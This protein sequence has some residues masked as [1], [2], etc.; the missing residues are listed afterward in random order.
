MRRYQ[1]VVEYAQ[2]DR[3]D[4]LVGLKGENDVMAA[5]TK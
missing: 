3:V 5:E 2:S 1:L 4:P